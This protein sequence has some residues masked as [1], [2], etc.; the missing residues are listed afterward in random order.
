MTSE[1]PA[2]PAMRGPRRATIGLAVMAI[3]A[4]GAS[5]GSTL[6][7]GAPAGHHKAKHHSTKHVAVGSDLGALDI[8]ATSAAISM[9]LYQHAGEDVQ[10]S[11][12]YSLATLGTGGIGNGVSS[13]LWPGATGAHGGDTLNLLGIPGLPKSVA[14]MLNDP[15]IAQAQTGVGDKTVD[16]SRPG[17]TMTASATSTNV[18]A[19][20][21]AG[22]SGVPLLGPI[23]GSVT[24]K[25]TIKVSGPRTVTVNAISTLHNLSIA[26]V[27]KIGT[28]TSTAHAVTNGHK[29]TGHAKTTVAGVTIA[30]IKVSI[31][32]KG[33][34]IP[35]KTLPIVGNTAAKLVNAALK[36]AG[37]HIDVTNSKR[38]I[39]GA[40]A[41]LDAGA[42]EV[43]FGNKS[44]T[45]NVNDTGKLITIGGATINA[46]ARPGFP[47]PPPIKQ[48][49]PVK[50]NPPPVQPGTPGTPGTPGVPGTSGV[51]TGPT[52]AVPPTSSLAPVLAGNPV[53]L[54]GG[55][56]PWWLVV[57]LIGAGL[58]AL[59][60]KRLPDQVLQTAGTTCSL[61]E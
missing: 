19:E 3:A 1:Q 25:S 41:S 21:S 40:H 6:A 5:T 55:L 16:L 27:I 46:Q 58:F 34:H 45:S 56:K 49:P 61:E 11:I 26:K 38:K 37:V 4:V 30:G 57:G 18:S 17:L 10:A 42:L 15:E 9:P 28:V 31:D 2:R 35:G 43:G 59:G 54:P 13:I 14:Q 8:T 29:A 20:T 32:N 60:M 44:Y 12:P 53:S 50:T 36:S 7:Q 47:P 48:P 22:G 52:T 24:S 39:K 33:V 23:I 51:P